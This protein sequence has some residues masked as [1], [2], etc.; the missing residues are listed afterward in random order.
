M[1]YI[2]KVPLVS[3]EESVYICDAIDF[4]STSKYILL[5]S[6]LSVTL[7]QVKI[8]CNS[9]FSC[10]EAGKTKAN[11]FLTSV[12]CRHHFIENLVEICLGVC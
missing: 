1:V 10:F 7:F 6:Q 11:Q 3:I 2:H 12:F 8:C 4:N 5:K 9:L